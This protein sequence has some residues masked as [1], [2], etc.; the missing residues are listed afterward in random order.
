MRRG[1]GFRARASAPV[2]PRGC[3]PRSAAEPLRS[4]CV[5][6][7]GLA[8]VYTEL[9]MKRSMDD[10]IYWQNVQLYSFGVLFNAAA[11]LATDARRGFAD[12]RGRRRPAAATRREL[13]P[14]AGVELPRCR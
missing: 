4:A 2:A 1:G 10:S 13:S 9:L 12:G 14:L 5:G 3:A 6:L 8:G 7:A 11:L